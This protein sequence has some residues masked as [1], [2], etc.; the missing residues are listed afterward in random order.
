[1]SHKLQDVVSATIRVLLRRE[2]SVEA[3]PLGHLRY[4]IGKSA[5]PQEPPDFGP[6]QSGAGISENVGKRLQ[7]RF[8]K[9]RIAAIGSVVLSAIPRAP[10]S[11]HHAQIMIT[12][13]VLLAAARP[14][15]L[16]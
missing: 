4:R 10:L 16:C 2:R 1:M 7:I 15:V 13:S 5:F 14:P 9:F 12:S 3:M 6:G 8:I 11:D